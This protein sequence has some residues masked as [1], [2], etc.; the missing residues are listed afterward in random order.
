MLM[1]MFDSHDCSHDDDD[2]DD[3]DDI[4]PLISMMLS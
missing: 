1:L 4:L 2:D 3:D